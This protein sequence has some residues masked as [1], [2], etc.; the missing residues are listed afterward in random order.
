VFERLPLDVA[1][2]AIRELANMLSSGLVREAVR[3]F[4]RGE[5]VICYC[6]T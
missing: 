4:R 3:I 5:S 6:R 2:M 1:E